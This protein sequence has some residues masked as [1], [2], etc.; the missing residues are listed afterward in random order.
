MSD[1]SKKLESGFTEY[2]FSHIRKDLHNVKAMN[3]PT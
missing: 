1:E 3:T 2:K